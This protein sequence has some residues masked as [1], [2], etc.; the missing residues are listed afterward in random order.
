MSRNPRIDNRRSLH[1]ISTD[2]AQ[3]NQFLFYLNIYPTNLF[4][5]ACQHLL[6]KNPY[7]SGLVDQT[8]V[9]A[10]QTFVAAVD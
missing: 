9:V 4:R 2:R 6:F 8:F 7:S 5:V 1:I 10:D 3:S